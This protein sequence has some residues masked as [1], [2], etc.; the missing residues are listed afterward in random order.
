MGN[1]PSQLPI[2]QD[3]AAAHALHNAAGGLQKPGVRHP[4]HQ[5]FR[6]LVRIGDLDDFPF[7]ELGAGFIQ[8]DQQLHRAASH[9]FLGKNFQGLPLGRF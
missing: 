4:N 7:I 8:A 6:Q 5:V 1:R 9:L 3:G 2:L